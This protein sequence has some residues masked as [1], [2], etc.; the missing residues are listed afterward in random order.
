M[1]FRLR[2]PGKHLSAWLASLQ[3]AT[4]I[5]VLLEGLTEDHVGRDPWQEGDPEK[6]H[7]MLR[8]LILQELLTILCESGG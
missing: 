8:L 7:A 4:H 3:A 1:T 6:Q 5:I 2:I